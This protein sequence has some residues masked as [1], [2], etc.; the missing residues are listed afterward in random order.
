MKIYFTIFL[1]LI[2]ICF[3]NLLKSKFAL[4]PENAEKMIKEVNQLGYK[5]FVTALSKLMDGASKKDRNDL[6]DAI[7]RL[8]QLNNVIVNEVVVPVKNLV[9]TQSEID[10]DKSISIPLSN[11]SKM[12]Q[13]LFCGDSPIVTGDP[14][15]PIIVA[16]KKYIVDG[17]HRW[18]Q[19]YF[20]NPDC[21]MKAYNMENINDPAVALKSAQLEIAGETGKIKTEKVKGQNLIGIDEKSLKDYVEKYLDTKDGSKVQDYLKSTQKPEFKDK[22][23]IKEYFW[24]NVILINNNNKPIPGA[25]NRTYMPQ[26]TLSF[27]VYADEKLVPNSADISAN[28]SA[29]NSANDEY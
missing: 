27:K 5:D 22:S 13:Y 8:A 1:I 25:T 3:N 12:Q 20:T 10:V 16:N 28:N 2:P 4:K 11:V 24:N 15:T 17:H 6:Q 29:N 19:V 9:P 18:S 7:K 21:L 14:L 26:T 23:L